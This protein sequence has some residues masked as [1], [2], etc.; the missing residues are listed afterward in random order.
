M[1]TSFKKYTRAGMAVAKG[2]RV[3]FS[4]GDEKKIVF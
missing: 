2:F 1:G 3:F 4:K